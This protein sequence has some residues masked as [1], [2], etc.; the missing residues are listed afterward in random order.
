[1]ANMILYFNVPMKAI[2]WEDRSGA[3][4]SVYITQIDFEKERK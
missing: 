2:V 1:M 4:V 3:I